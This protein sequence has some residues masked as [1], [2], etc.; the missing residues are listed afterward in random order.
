MNDPDSRVRFYALEGL[1][2]VLKVS[3]LH[4]IFMTYELNALFQVCKAHLLPHF[5]ELYTGLQAPVT[6][7]DNSVRTNVEII[8]KLLKVL[9]I[10]SNHSPSKIDFSLSGCCH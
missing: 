6:D 2:N 5:T 1:Y 9:S 7:L 3:I 4:L 8:N 10:C